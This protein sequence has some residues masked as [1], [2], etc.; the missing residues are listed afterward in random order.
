MVRYGDMESPVPSPSGASDA[1]ALRALCQRACAGDVDAAEQLLIHHHGRL[2]GFV[3]RKL[4][5]DWQGKLDAE[6]ILQD[7]YVRIF[8]SISQF[9]Y[10]GEDSFYQWA[11][12][13]V[14]HAFIDAVRGL[15]RK[16][17]DV[18]RETSAGR[19]G[20]ERRQSLL[21]QVLRD[22]ITP[23]R[24]MRREDALA[25]MM[26]CIARLPEDYRTVIQ[27]HHLEEIPLKQVATELGRSEDAVRRLAG[28][29]VQQLNECLG[30]ASRYLSMRS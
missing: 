23:S 10:A 26:A 2:C 24:I 20:D 11:S 22:S 7:G 30:N 17:R 16:K 6:D 12:R 4:G 14:D 1:E 25:A 9:H 8:A 18:A 27:R 19:D 28:R 21:D 29:A 3:R 15:R 5:V 13:V